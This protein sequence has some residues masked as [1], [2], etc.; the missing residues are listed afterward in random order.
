MQYGAP[1]AEVGMSLSEVDTPALVI[2]LEPYERNLR[3]MAKR[4]ADHPVKLRAHAKTHKCAVIARHQMALGA[5]GVCCQKVGEAEALV[6]G[7][8][9][10][11][12]ISNQIVGRGKIERL[13]ALS[14]E[15]K[16]MVCCDH[17]RNADALSEIATE[18]GVDL[19]ILVEIDC[20]S[21]RCGV[22]P[23]ADAVELARYIESLPGLSFAGLQ[24]YQGR[25]QHVRGYTERQVAVRKAAD[26]TRQTVQLLADGG[27]E[28]DVVSGAGTGTFEFEMT[29]GVHNEMQAGSYVFMDADY[30]R[31]LDRAG[32]PVSDF[33]HSLF[34]LATVMSMNRPG[35]AVVDAGLKAFSVDQ[36]LPW[37]FERPGIEFSRISDEHGTLGCDE[38][39][40]L[41]LG[42]KLLFIPG[43]CDP[44]VNL[45]DW[46][47]C[48]R[49]QRV[50]ALWPI[51]ARGAVR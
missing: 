5:V 35:H 34:V 32:E 15:A 9:D 13:V 22:N 47:V 27:L 30:G 49:N 23:G 39:V 50:E 14:R 10:D 46:Y 12:L 11:V 26:L 37:A 1:P 36:G 16:V 21:G 6:R 41:E 19:R 2:D 33:E 25:A 7:G 38:D 3:R 31:N 8:V 18:R 29:Y 40:T 28:C 48:V 24:S 4:L 43:H 45:Y 42:E 20:G 44:T 51:V 17:R